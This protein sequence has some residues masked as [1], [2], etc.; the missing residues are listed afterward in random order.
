MCRGQIRLR[1]KNAR[2]NTICV[3]VHRHVPEPAPAHSDDFSR[4]DLAK[5]IADYPDTLDVDVGDLEQLL[6]AA[7]ENAALRRMGLKKK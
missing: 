5:A 2:G 6:H 4:A 7:E 3:E 1:R